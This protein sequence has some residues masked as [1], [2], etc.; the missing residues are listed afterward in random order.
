MLLCDRSVVTPVLNFK[1]MK[2]VSKCRLS[3]FS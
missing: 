1:V 3:E 2:V